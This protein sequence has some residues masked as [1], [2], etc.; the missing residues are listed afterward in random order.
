MKTTRGARLDH[1]TSLIIGD[2][3]HHTVETELLERSMSGRFDRVVYLGDYFDDFGDT[4]ERMRCTCRWL[5]ETLDRPNR[6]HLLGNH[7]LAF[8][9]PDNPQLSCPGWSWEKQRIFDLECRNLPRE[10]F[11]LAVEVNGWLLSHA[12]FHP[13]LAGRKRAK[14][15]VHDANV[16]L[17]AALAGTRTPML[18]C[19]Y[20]RGGGDRIGGLTWLDWDYEFEPIP[21]LNQIVGH[22]P[23]RGVVRGHHLDAAGK[24][25]RSIISREQTPAPVPNPGVEWRSLNWCIDCHGAYATLVSSDGCVFVPRTVI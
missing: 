12:G 6:I 2:V 9:N 21:G 5:N 22:T 18:G 20:G 4:P 11:A 10:R 16:A 3:H 24:K 23:A 7:D 15:L 17:Q 19:G 25:H 14:T 8:F 1:S 13:Q